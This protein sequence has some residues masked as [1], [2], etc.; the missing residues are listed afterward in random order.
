MWG[1][2]AA[3]SEIT[4]V[5]EAH[6]AV[7]QLAR[8]RVR[9]QLGSDSLHGATMETTASEVGEGDAELQCIL[10]GNRVRRFKEFEALPR[11]QPTVRLQ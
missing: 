10:R 2:Q 3:G 8:E 11:P 9:A 5:A 4:Q 1:G 7:R 6:M